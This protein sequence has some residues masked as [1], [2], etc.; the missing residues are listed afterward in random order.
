MKLS[1]C[2]IGTMVITKDLEVGHVVGIQYNVGLAL[3][4]GMT[5]EDKF[6][7]TIPTVKFPDG[8]RG[9]HHGNLKI[10]RD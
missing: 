6:S 9:V 1:E 5:N 4:G 2:K 7:R 3:T 8:E 10:F